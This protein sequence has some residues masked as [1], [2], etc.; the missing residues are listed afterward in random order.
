M[1]VCLN[2]KGKIPNTLWTI[3]CTYS[4]DYNCF[5]LSKVF[6]KIYSTDISIATVYLYC[7][8]IFRALFQTHHTL[9]RHL[10]VVFFTIVPFSLTES[11]TEYLIAPVFWVTITLLCQCRSVPPFHYFFQI[12]ITWISSCASNFIKWWDLGS[13]TYDT[14]KSCWTIIITYQCTVVYLASYSYLKR[15]T[16]NATARLGSS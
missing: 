11:L 5:N 9:T 14:Q 8:W 2:R 1:H 7:F 6:I 4:I 3:T 13:H 15:E 10:L 16:E 12:Y